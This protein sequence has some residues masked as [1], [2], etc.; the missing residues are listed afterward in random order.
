MNI[1]EN[2]NSLNKNLQNFN[3]INSKKIALF[4]LKLIHKIFNSINIFKHNNDY[5]IFIYIQIIQ[6]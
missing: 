5:I 2:E 1:L 6:I 4:N 3:Q